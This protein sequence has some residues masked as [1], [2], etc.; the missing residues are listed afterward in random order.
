MTRVLA[1]DLR[2]Q[3]ILVNTVAPGPTGTELFFKGKSEQLIQTFVNANPFG[4][5]GEPDEIAVIVAFLVFRD[6]RWVNGQLIRVN[7]GMV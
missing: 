5:L 3:G 7:R 1:K 4:K 6:S 2:G